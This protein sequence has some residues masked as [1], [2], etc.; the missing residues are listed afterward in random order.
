MRLAGTKAERDGPAR[1]KLLR[2]VRHRI[3]PLINRPLAMLAHALLPRLGLLY[4]DLVW[5]TSRV[6]SE[7]LSA[8][9]QIYEEH[10]GLVALL[11]HEE[12]ATVAYAYSQA[13]LGFQPHTLA[14]PGDAGEVITRMLEMSGCVVF[15]GG[16]T[17]HQSRRREGV[18]ED[19]IEHM[20]ERDAVFYG[21]TVDGSKGPAY[22]M[23]S[24]G[25]VIARECGKPIALIRIWYRRCFRLRTWDRTAIPLPWNEIRYYLRGPYFIP[26]D[27]ATPAGLERFRL[28][29]ER[30]LIELARQSSR[31][32]SQPAPASLQPRS[33]VVESANPS[34]A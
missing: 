3:R 33:E 20:R 15:R 22:R 32:M 8:L 21:I 13:K 4:L 5:K 17:R 12:I 23:K 10:Q 2:R 18:L 29:L 14:S 28:A 6:D 26:A 27:A 25:L 16:S 34:N 11:W 24:G 7:S 31:D 30:D 1:R 19:L 9:R